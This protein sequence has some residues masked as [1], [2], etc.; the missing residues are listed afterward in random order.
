MVDAATEFKK[1]GY[2]EEDSAMLAQISAMYQ[3]VADDAISASDASSFII[4]QMKAFN[5]DASDAISIVDQ[6][7]AVSN[8]YAVSSSEL[9]QGLGIVS[10]AL[11]I[12]GN[13]YQ[14]VLGLTH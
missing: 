4:A 6:L 7:N 3:N 9:A 2:S 10:S 13:N 12:G 1:S 11:A 5:V 14:E 8:N